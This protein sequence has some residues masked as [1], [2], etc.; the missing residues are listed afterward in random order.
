MV[1]HEPRLIP[2]CLDIRIQPHGLLRIQAQRRIGI[3]AYFLQNAKVALR[4]FQRDI[5]FGQLLIQMLA[6]D[7]ADQRHFL[8]RH[9]DLI[10]FKR[11]PATVAR[12]RARIDL[13]AAFHLHLPALDQNVPAVALSA[14][15]GE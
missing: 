13:C 6:T 10:R 15:R 2:A 9:A 14:G 11:Q 4:G 1:H 5:V 3:P 8:R 7:T 12:R